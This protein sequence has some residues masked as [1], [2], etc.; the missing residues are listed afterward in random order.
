MKIINE[1]LLFWYIEFPGIRFSIKVKN[2]EIMELQHFQGTPLFT[3]DNNV[4]IIVICPNYKETF[5][6]SEFIILIFL[7]KV[8]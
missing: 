8:N 1:S 7:I 5:K 4:T 6:I 2:L 3:A